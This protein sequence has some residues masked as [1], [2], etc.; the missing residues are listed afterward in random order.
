M[1]KYIKQIWVHLS[2]DP[3]VSS[4]TII[5]TALALFLIMLVVMIEQVKYEPF[6]PESNRD[7]FMHARFMSVTN[8][9][10]G[11]GSSNGPMSIETA[12][13]LYKSLKTPEAVTLY[14]ND[15]PAVASVAGGTTFVADIL[16]T[17]A[18]FWKVFDFDFINGAPYGKA[19]FDAGIKEAV[20]IKSLALRLFGTPDVAGREFMINYT[21]YKVAGVVKDVS[22]L[23]SKAYSQI[24]IPYTCTDVEKNTWSRCGGS[25][26]TT[27]LARRHDDFPK[28][29]EE[30]G[31]LLALY[32]KKI[33]ESGWKILSRNRPYIQEKEAFTFSANHEVNMKAKH[34]DRYIILII[35]LL[36]PAINLSSM[37]QSRL[38]HR[39]AEIGVRRSFGCTRREILIDIINENLI[40]TLI[41][42]ALGLIMSIAFAYWGTD[43]LFAQP[44]SNSLSSPTIDTSI[45][46]HAS[47]FIYAIVFCFILNLLCS[48]IP[49]WRAS[50][51]SIINA[52]GGMNH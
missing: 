7:R 42:G 32:N 3:L 25:F 49:A 37:T 24:W 9:K 22:T 14:A 6:S 18:D 29:R 36:V 23:A 13:A 34:R 43:I 38:Q 50:K 8:A 11:D 28:I 27:I 1:R 5:G 31:K 48:Y 47:T 46:L 41:A 26:S 35:L 39:N 4:I 30:Y 52:L 16:Q 10:W 21:A 20:I 12:K 45:L 33:G 40:I 44:F 19:D 17:D 2:H 51:T 15:N